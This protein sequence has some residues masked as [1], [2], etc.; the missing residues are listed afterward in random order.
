MLL[1]SL[2][3][4]LTGRLHR[5]DERFDP[6]RISF[7]SLAQRVKQAAIFL[8]FGVPEQYIANHPQRSRSVAVYNA[9]IDEL[10]KAFPEELDAPIFR[11]MIFQSYNPDLVQRALNSFGPLKKNVSITLLQARML[12]VEMAAQ[13]EDDEDLFETDTLPPA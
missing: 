5:M 1:E 4:V 10:Y 2:P 6:D 7:R 11:R 9:G 12:E 3:A 8:E 13:Y